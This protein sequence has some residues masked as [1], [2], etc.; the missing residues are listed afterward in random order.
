MPEHQ[1]VRDPNRKQ[2]QEPQKAT[3]HRA[4][5]YPNETSSE[6]PYAQAQQA[7]YETPCDL[8]TYRLQIGPEYE[9]HVAVLGSPPP[10]E[11]LRRV[12][13]ILATGEQVTLS[14]EAVAALTLRRLQQI[15]R[16]P[17]VEGHY[18]KRRSKGDR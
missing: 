13:E 16:G 11:L 10:E 9:W 1:R 15:Q 6:Q 18:G 7:I 4:A 2:K 5:R 8:S 14:D 3:F 12:E 17:W